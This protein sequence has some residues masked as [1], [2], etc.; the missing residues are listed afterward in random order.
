MKNT[1]LPERATAPMKEGSEM[2]IICGTDLSNNCSETVAVAN[3]LAGQLK[4][5]L[6]VV[7]VMHPSLQ[8]RLAKAVE[9]MHHEECKKSLAALAG[10]LN[11]PGD[12]VHTHLLKGHADERMVTL[13]A[14]EEAELLVVGSHAYRDR[15]HL[16]LGSCAERVAE[17][18]FTPT[19]VVR[20]DGCKRRPKSAAGWRSK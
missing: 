2:K 1:T 17:S 19:L 11:A 6:D 4:A 20:T 10:S 14:D 12:R 5:H 3:T 9:K 8:D 7:H 16:R 18:S 15:S 13:A